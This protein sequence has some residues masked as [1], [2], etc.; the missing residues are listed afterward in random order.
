MIG[1]I[2]ATLLSIILQNN[3]V[4]TTLIYF[5][6]H[7]FMPMCLYWVVKFSMP[8]ER[9]LKWLFPVAIFITVS[10][11]AIGVISWIM[12]SILPSDTSVATKGVLHH[13]DNAAIDQNRLRR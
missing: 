12:P 11:V 6:D 7:V 10:Q 4:I 2:A 13:I 5:Y 3:S 9:S 8:G 1:Y